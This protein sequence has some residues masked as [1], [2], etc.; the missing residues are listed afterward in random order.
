M[1]HRE[2]SRWGGNPIG[3]AFTGT[4]RSDIKTYDG[5][6]IDLR[7]F[8][9][10]N[11]VSSISYM[12]GEVLIIPDYIHTLPS[13]V[14]YSVPRAI[15]LLY[16]GVVTFNSFYQSSVNSWVVYVP[17]SQLSAYNDRYASSSGTIP[18]KFRPISECPYL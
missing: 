13:T 17:D 7:I 8:P 1:K 18:K 4:D 2:K 9:N 16:N 12:S 15:I 5:N 14:D 10:L 6:I 11:N 3:T